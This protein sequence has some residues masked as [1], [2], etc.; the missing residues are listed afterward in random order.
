M[1]DS[2]EA[3][4]RRCRARWDATD[5][6]LF[7]ASRLAF[8]LAMGF[9]CLAYH[10]GGKWLSWTGCFE[11][12]PRFPATISWTLRAHLPK[13]LFD[14]FFSAGWAPL[15]RIFWRHRCDA[16]LAFALQM[17][18]TSVVAMTLSP[19]G[20]SEAADRRHYVASFLYML[21]HLAC[22]A[23]VD[24]P[25]TYVAA[26]KL[27]F[28]FLIATTLALRALKARF[29]VHIAPNATSDAIRDT[30]AKLPQTG[31][32]LCFATEFAEMIFEY[33]MFIAFIQGLG[34]AGSI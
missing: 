20:V 7:G 6:R 15:L 32:R 9:P 27:A 33:A 1:L 21:D 19:V 14:V 34:A 11:P 4:A 17:V 18:A 3:S 29:A 2:F 22:C 13:R 28:G 8:L 12:R 30:Y 24:M 16:A 5:R 10:A 26:F 25:A 31:R 23:Y